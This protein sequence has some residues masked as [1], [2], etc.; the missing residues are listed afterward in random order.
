VIAKCAG[1]N[2]TKW[3]YV[4]GCPS[5]ETPKPP[6]P[7]TDSSN[8]NSSPSTDEPTPGPNPEPPTPEPPTDELPVNNNQPTDNPATDEVQPTENT[9]PTSDNGLPT[10]ETQPTGTDITIVVP[11]PLID[12][13]SIPQTDNKMW[14]EWTTA[15]EINLTGFKLW[16][17]SPVNGSCQNVTIQD[18][19]LQLTEELIEATSQDSPYS[20][21]SLLALPN[22]CYGLEWLWAMG[23]STIYIIGPGI[24]KWLKVELPQP[25]STP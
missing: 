15:F 1:D 14:F 22:Q 4:V 11:E 24:E 21:E 19:V 18:P 6:T 12:F 8:D 20:F 10:N 17:A 2:S 23:N 3:D 16:Q 25:L 7:T 13:R 5:K 9:Q